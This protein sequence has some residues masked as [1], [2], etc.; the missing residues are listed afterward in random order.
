MLFRSEETPAGVGKDPSLVVYDCIGGGLGHLVG[1]VE[2]REAA[3]PFD[4][5]PPID[6]YNAALVDH[7]FYKPK[8]V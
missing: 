7:V 6:A 2:G 8:P 3:Q 1:F 5:P 4:A